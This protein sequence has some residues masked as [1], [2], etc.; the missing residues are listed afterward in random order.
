M[1]FE[2]AKQQP[3]GTQITV[4]A[5]LT[6]VLVPTTELYNCLIQMHMVTQAKTFEDAAELVWFKFD[7]RKDRVMRDRAALITMVWRAARDGNVKPPF[8]IEEEY[9]KIVQAAD[10]RR[11]PGFDV[12]LTPGR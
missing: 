10:A 11:E 3:V 4:G 8:D 5:G 2:E 7:M 1:F 9:K 12:G 6:A